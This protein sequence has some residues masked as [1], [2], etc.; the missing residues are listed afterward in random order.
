VSDD[1]RAHVLLVVRGL[2]KRLAEH[3]IYTTPPMARWKYA[4]QTRN[5]DQ[6]GQR[7]KALAYYY[8]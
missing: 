4:I 8:L 5:A 6:H 7:P 2:R 3:D 1:L